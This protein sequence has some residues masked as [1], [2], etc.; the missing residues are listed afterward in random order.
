MAAIE[1]ETGALAGRGGSSD[2]SSC[3]RTCR[4]G[5]LQSASWRT[6]PPGDDIVL[7]RR[8]GFAAP[9]DHE[10]LLR[11]ANVPRNGAFAPTCAGPRVDSVQGSRLTTSLPTN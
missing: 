1:Y 5:A 6:G 3:R 9:L 2:R 8:P 7:A 11:P 10:P 4:I